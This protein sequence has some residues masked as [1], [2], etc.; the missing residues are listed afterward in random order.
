[1]TRVY[2][3]AVVFEHWPGKGRYI[4]FHFKSHKK[5]VYN[6]YKC[7]PAVKA[8]CKNHGSC[9]KTRHCDFTATGHELVQYAM[10]K[11]GLLLPST[12]HLPQGFTLEGEYPV[13]KN[14]H[15]YLSR[16]DS[17]ENENQYTLKSTGSKYSRKTVPGVGVECFFLI[18]YNFLY[19][20]E[21]SNR[22]RRYVTRFYKK[23]FGH[24]FSFFFWRL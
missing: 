8:L 14:M 23:K 13:C 22:K 10:C 12:L 7:H 3:L 5:M 18:S 20:F 1:M 11:G 6:K 15:T 21:F 19:Y 17:G 4:N 16:T 9:S 24:F 2:V